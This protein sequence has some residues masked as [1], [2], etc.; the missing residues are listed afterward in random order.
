METTFFYKSF[1]H[2]LFDNNRFFCLNV[3]II[4]A[5][6]AFAYRDWPYVFISI[7]E[8][9]TRNRCGATDRTQEEHYNI[10]TGIAPLLAVKIASFH[11]D[12]FVPGPD[13]IGCADHDGNRKHDQI[14]GSTLSP[15][16]DFTSPSC[17]ISLHQRRLYSINLPGSAG[18]VHIPRKT[19]AVTIVNV[20]EDHRSLNTAKVIA[21]GIRLSRPQTTGRS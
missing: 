14:D 21:A 9:R 10:V 3:H 1:F 13:P 12:P 5:S 4:P 7:N 8:P 16:H 15:V 11:T 20:S 17:P 19:E 6:W 2:Y 18:R